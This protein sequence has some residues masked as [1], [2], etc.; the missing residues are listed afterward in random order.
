M[1]VIGQG[2]EERVLVLQE[3]KPEEGAAKVTDP[4]DFTTMKQRMRY[5]MTKEVKVEEVAI[6]ATAPTV[7]ASDDKAPAPTQTGTK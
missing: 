4:F 1:R 2:G 6:P 5:K 3:F 7:P